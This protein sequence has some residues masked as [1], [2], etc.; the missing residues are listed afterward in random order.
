[1]KKSLWICA[2]TLLLTSC[3]K[4]VCPL[5]EVYRNSS[6]TCEKEPCPPKPPEEGPGSAQS[7][8]KAASTVTIE[9]SL[10]NSYRSY[11]YIPSQPTP[12]KA[13]VLLYLHGYFDSTPEP[14]DAM[15]RHYAQNGYIVIYVSYGNALYAQAWP[16][17]AQEAYRRA[18]AYLDK[19]SAVKPD[20][21]NVAFIGHS[22]GGILAF[23]LA[24]KLGAGLEETPRPKLIA[25]SDAAGISTIAYPHV[26]ID[27]LAGIPKDTKM[28]LMLAEET[29]EAR[30]KEEDR[31][32]DDS[33]KPARNCNG[34]G[35]NLRAMRRTPQIPEANKIALLISGDKQGESELKSDHNGAQGFCGDDERPI[36]A[37]DTWGY[38]RNTLTALNAVL[39]NRGEFSTL[40]SNQSLEQG[41]WSNGKPAKAARILNSCLA[42]G[43]CPKR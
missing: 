40:R 42:A 22:I 15:L 29:Y 38:W 24:H 31:C 11:L 34:F 5:E 25:T 36:N 43:D 26:S 13:P 4:D 39:K 28:L 37:I 20:R 12:Q 41:L 7:I 8:H 9:E 14:Y 1:M 18:L 30:F 10:T 16:D 27:N 23:H 33:R 3:A 17:N 32:E 21:D 35:V 2:L 19:N 6:T